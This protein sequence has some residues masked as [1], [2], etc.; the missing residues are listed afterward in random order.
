[1]MDVLEFSPPYWLSGICLSDM[2]WPLSD[3]TNVTLL[4]CA[5]FGGEDRHLPLEVREY[6]VLAR[7]LHQ[8]DYRP[9][10]LTDRTCAQTAA[11]QTGLLDDRLVAL[12][13]RGISLGFYLE[14]WQRRDYWVV[15]RA[16]AAYPKRIRQLLRSSAP[17]VLFGTGEPKLLDQGATAVIGP[18]HVMEQSNE[19]ARAMAALCA[20]H[21]RI[22]I[23][24]GKQTIS[25]G[26]VKSGIDSG[27][28]VIWV[29]Q[30]PVFGEPL[31]KSF[32]RAK[33]AGKFMMLSGRSPADKR[34]I[35]QEPEIGRIAMALCDS[36]IY[37]DGTELSGDRYCLEE[38]MYH[39]LDQR[40][41]FVSCMGQATAAAERL[42]EGGAN[43]WIGEEMAVHEGLF[44]DR[45][46]SRLQESPEL[47][48]LEGELT[49]VESLDTEGIGEDKP[50]ADAGH[51][52]DDVQKDDTS[53]IEVVLGRGYG[54]QLS[55][56][57][58]V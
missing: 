39:V 44:E 31:R 23:A 58:S 50:K 53:R 4:L 29:L 16:D 9:R 43:S 32:R 11:R 40:Q 57:E 8:N 26:V 21:H 55:I 56:F 49:Q 34:P 48:D 15:G 27:G 52:K 41:C 19:H 12:L 7:W 17:P 1:M 45:V 38:A 35:S 3:D 51:E 14:E 18:D 54:K 25:S 6:N 5:W 36:A 47:A 33:A 10:N 28:S 46:E 22:T 30:G 37:I 42:L 2:T 20:Q 24:A 13:D